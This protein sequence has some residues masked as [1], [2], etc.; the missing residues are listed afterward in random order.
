MK[1]IKEPLSETCAHSEDEKLKVDIEQIREIIDFL[2]PKLD[3]YEQAVYWY[4]VR[5]TYLKE[6]PTTKTT[7][8]ISTIGDKI[9]LGYGRM[10]KAASRQTLRKKIINLESKGYIKL[11]RN[12][13]SGHEYKVFLPRDIN[14]CIPESKGSKE[15]S[16][17][18]VDFFNTRENKLKILE[19]E[20]YKCFYCQKEITES[21]FAVDHIQ[22][23]SEGGDNSYKNCVASCID[24]NSAKQAKNVED[25]ARDLMRARIISNE[26]FSK[27]LKK[28]EALKN[29]ELK[30]EI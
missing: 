20:K 12:S 4:L 16:L 25:F 17:D 1:G 13:Y 7:I 22:P 2:M 18:E 27:L 15:I 19:R 3:V 10:G 8:G 14:G 5:N 11:I 28:V 29:G 6:N 23:R 30:P 21:N 26:E 9:S 24:C